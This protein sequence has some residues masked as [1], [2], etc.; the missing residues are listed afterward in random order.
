MFV[1]CSCLVLLCYVLSIPSSLSA[2][3]PEVQ[4]I[5]SN[6]VAA[7][8][9]DFKAAPNF[10]WKER[11]RTPGGSKTFQVTMIEGTPYNRLIA[12]NDQ[13]LSRERAQQEMQKQQQ[14]AA[15]RRSES[16]EARRDRIA[17]YERERK[18]DNILMEQL[19]KAFEFKLVGTKTVRHFHVWVLKA[20][21]LP[22]YQPPNR[23][24]Q[25]LTGMEGEMWIDQKT[26]NWVR[27]HAIVIHPVS[28]EGFLAQVQPG[29]RFE[30]EKAPVSGDIWQFTHF[31]MKAHAKVLFMFN[32]SSEE[33]DTYWDY[34]PVNQPAN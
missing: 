34:Q 22:G 20:T 21:P 12:E 27:V 28:I 2:Q 25:V 24:A 31:A 3:E 33:D 11:D 18:R 1:K 32:H 4:Q 30:V 8:E 15:K 23:D 13:P 19:T 5:I 17:K 10:N 26:D 16:P 14:E 7:N 29:T 6:S 9:R